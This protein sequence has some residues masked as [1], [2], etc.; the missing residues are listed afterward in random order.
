VLSRYALG[1]RPYLSRTALPPDVCFAMANLA[2]V[3]RSH[4]V[5]DP[6]CGSAS[7]LLCCA[8]LGARTLGV[9]I[10]RRIFEPLGVASIADNFAAADLPMPELLCAIVR[11]AQPH[12]V[13]LVGACLRW[14]CP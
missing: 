12:C 13:G 10:D 5:L 1:S 6:F 3:R 2:H 8:H 11:H 9:E 14:R 7:T 4:A